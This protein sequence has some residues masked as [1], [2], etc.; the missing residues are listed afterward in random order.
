MPSFGKRSR[1]QLETCHPDLQKVLN[2]AIKEFDFTILE[3]E[4]TLE[5]QQKYYSIGRTTK[6]NSGIITN[7][8]GIKRKSRHQSSPSVAVDIAPWPID[9]SDIARFK[10]LAQV[11]MKV[12]QWSDIGLEWGGHWTRPIDYPHYQL[13]KE[14]P[15]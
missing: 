3:G 10:S 12:S 13:L 7:C 2:E 1:S 4:R 15:K 9:W 5:T 11:M 14:T 8:D 6:I